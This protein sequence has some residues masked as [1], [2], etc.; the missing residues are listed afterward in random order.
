MPR[1][2]PLS[3]GR[4]TT[5]PP[6]VTIHALLDEPSVMCPLRS[7]N[8]AS[9]APRSRATCFASTLGKSDVDAV[10]GNHDAR[11]GARR[12]ETMIAPRHAAGD[13]QIDDSVAEPVPPHTLAHHDR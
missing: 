3:A 2:I 11:A 12:R 5:F 7:T 8:H 1:R 4:V 9:L 10:R 13:L 6:R